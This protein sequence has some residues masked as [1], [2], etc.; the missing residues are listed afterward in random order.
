MTEQTDKP[1]ITVVIR[2]RR[3]ERVVRFVHWTRAE[4][5]AAAIDRIVRRVFGARSFV[6]WG[7]VSGHGAI[8]TTVDVSPAP[9]AK[10]V[11]SFRLVQNDVT[12]TTE[13]RA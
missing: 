12:I 9:G 7:R 8:Y 1:R 13:S 5:E 3:G 2:Y 11:R 4:S 10:C 6:R